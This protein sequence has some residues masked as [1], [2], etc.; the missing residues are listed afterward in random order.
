MN[1]E[2][3]IK[4]GLELSS[5]LVISGFSYSFKTNEEQQDYIDWETYC[6]RFLKTNYSGDFNT[7]EFVKTSNYK[8]DLKTRISK[9]VLQAQFMR[10]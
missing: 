6:I 10:F 8:G 9:Q 1:I 3:L 7:E 5:K 2:D 4:D